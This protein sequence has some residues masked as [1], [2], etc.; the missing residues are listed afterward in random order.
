MKNKNIWKKEYINYGL[1]LV[2]ITLLCLISL[3]SS[4]LYKGFTDVDSSVFQIMGKGI[5]NGQIMYKDLFDH[6]GPI[7]YLINAIAYLIS[8]QIGL[9]L[10]EIVF[11]YIG[12]IYVYKTS[13]I[14]LEEK[15][16]FIVSLIYLVAS[17][18]F[19]LGGNFT[20]E[21]AITI[22]S[23]AMYYIIKILYNS[24]YEKKVN[25]IL[26]GFTFAIN[27]FIKPTYISIWIAF[28]IIELIYFVKKRKITDLIKYI[29]Y[30]MI[31]IL[32]VTIPIFIYLIINNDVKDFINAYIYLNMK[33]SKYT[34][35]EKV[36]AFVELVKMCKYYIFLLI[37]LLG[38]IFIFSNKEINKSIK[39][40]VTLFFIISIIL[41]SWAANTY[42][43][44]LIQLAPCVALELIFLLYNIK[45]L[46]KKEKISKIV[47]DLP[48]NLLYICVI[49]VIT[50]NIC[51][52]SSK[53]RGIFAVNSE[54]W[55]YAKTKI[56]EL[57]NYI[58]KDDEILVLG[59]QSYYYIFFN[60]Q[61]KFKYFFQTPIIE[62]DET[63]RKDTEKYI[64]EKKPQ[65]I[66]K[67]NVKDDF[68]DIYGQ[69]IIKEL[70]Q[71]YEERDIGIFRYCILK[72]N[73]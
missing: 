40:F 16:S 26:I 73:L 69:E 25:W 57:K 32:I 66:I 11:F 52:I 60:K 41:T 58:D 62:Y 68:E 65:I 67:P 10:I 43:H 49:T 44:Y 56:S 72:E 15:Y 4:P 46:I 8:P 42:S 27:F 7:V 31:G 12:V 17:F 2:I 38:N 36:R 3:C 34:A 54:I 29:G 50:I 61:P 59:N 71:K 33:Y 21:Y 37:M 24:E 9:L 53:Q 45:K 1:I 55:D 18:K 13:R 51:W 6:K 19:I 35:I 23:I 63:I 20:E 5:L 64:K 30:M 22:L 14:F 48:K 70:N 47:D 39:G 28:G